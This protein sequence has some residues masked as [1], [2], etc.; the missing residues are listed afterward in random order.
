MFIYY[1]ESYRCKRFGLKAAEKIII[2][3]TLKTQMVLGTNG[4]GKSSLLKF[5]MTVI[6]PGK[7]HFHTGGHKIIKLRHNGSKYRLETHYEKSSPKHVF[8]QDG[9]SLNAGG[10]GVVQMELI[11][12]HFGITEEIHKVITGM[13]R[14][15]DMNT[16]ERRDWITRLSS[17]DF[18]YVL[19]LYNRVR[20]AARDQDAIIRNSRSRLTEE[21]PKLL[22][23]DKEMSLLEL[24][25]RLHDR[26]DVLIHERSKLNRSQ[27]ETVHELKSKM[28]ELERRIG[29]FLK[30]SKIVGV[31]GYKIEDINDL[32]HHI[33]I[34]KEKIGK[35]ES[36][37][38]VL[39][40]QLSAIEAK[41][42]EI[43]SISGMDDQFVRRE[44]DTSTAELEQLFSTLRTNIPPNALEDIQRGDLV[45]VVE[46]RMALTEITTS[47]AERF[48][49]EAHSAARRE[50]DRLIE[51]HHR[52]HG[53]ISS[54]EGRLDHISRC[55][56]VTCPKCHH[57][58]KPG[59]GEHE[60]EVLVQGV[61]L[62]RNKLDQLLG[63]M[64]ELRNFVGEAQVYRGKISSIEQLRMTERGL[65]PLWSYIDD[66]GG[67][68]KGIGLT[69]PLLDFIEDVKTAWRIK[70]VR[71]K[72]ELY[73]ESLNK[74]EEASVN[75]SLINQQ[76]T[77]AKEAV[78]KTTREITFFHDE[79]NKLEDLLTSNRQIDEMYR[80]LKQDVV[81][82]NELRAELVE[83]IRQEHV[84][85][86][87][88]DSRN[89]LA[90]VSRT[91]NEHQTQKFLVDDIERE[92]IRAMNE[93]ILLKKIEAA[94]NPKDGLIA[95]QICLF[96]NVVINKINEVIARVWGFNMALLPL[97]LET[98]PMDYNFP[99]Y[100][101]TKDND[102][103]DVSK[104]SDSM[105]EIVDQAFRLVVYKMMNLKDFPLYIDELGKGFDPVHR[106]NLI[107]AIK[108]MI[109]DP[110]Y[111]QVFIISHYEDGQNSYPNSEII[112]TE[113]SH[114]SLTREYNKHVVFE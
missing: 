61:E 105:R 96:I 21:K 114:I 79:L 17:T 8:I 44:L 38:S 88:E 30:N 95:E 35:K 12:E 101:G 81:R 45:K 70:E 111:S 68:S 74:F 71:S 56:E 102:C 29:V 57:D 75:G 62:E 63:R 46:I 24:S 1:A 86:A 77:Q 66:L 16:Q 108:D 93:H 9:T 50:L 73:K 58:F 49:D 67:F 107:F 4:S 83:Q 34:L 59:V 92:H 110:M 51:E 31:P 52:L 109:D 25:A 26:L 6:P 27:D 5:I 14:F 112:V 85:E 82:V 104:G 89:G 2:R 43:R 53:N 94:M 84:S 36:V 22:D 91:L 60:M 76:Y 55:Q 28:V 54:V 39:G 20:R 11:R 65:A 19:D 69:E 113:D 15:S 90:S 48:T 13:R 23:A 106:A 47:V 72:V 7:E 98:K 40:E 87:I 37:L 42:S 100:N 99:L 3:P 80:V 10:T 41:V 97:D 64:N 103:D 32:H 18:S 33:T 78:E